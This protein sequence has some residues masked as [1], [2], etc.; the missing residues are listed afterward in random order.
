[1]KR[2]LQLIGGI[3]LAYSV[4]G[5][6]FHALANLENF[7]HHCE[8]LMLSTGENHL[9]V[10]TIAAAI[11]AAVFLLAAKARKKNRLRRTS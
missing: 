3:L 7:G 11:A 4:V 5:V 10:F 2:I 6:A 9:Q 1:M 8:V